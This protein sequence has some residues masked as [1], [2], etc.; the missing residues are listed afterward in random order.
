MGFPIKLDTNGSRPHTL[1]QLIDEGLVDYVAM[2]IKADPF[3][4]SP[5]I[6]E[7]YNPKDIVLSI[8]T[9][10]ESAVAYEFRTTCV[11]PIVGSYDIEIIAKNIKGAALYALQRFHKTKV[12]HPEFFGGLEAGYKE[13]ELYDLKSMADP[14]VKK[15]TIR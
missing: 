7:K 9:I 4:Y 10:M 14:W 3:R 15:C 11:K 5:L 8:Q 13:D 12:L 6:T 1:R 2:D